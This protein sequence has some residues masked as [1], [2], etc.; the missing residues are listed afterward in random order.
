MKNIK[1]YLA[2]FFFILLTTICTVTA[3]SG[4]EFDQVLE[5]FELQSDLVRDN[6][7]VIDPC[8]IIT[9]LQTLKAV[10]LLEEDLY[11]RTYLLNRRSIL[12]Y[13][14]WVL[15]QQQEGFYNWTI[16]AHAFYNQTT[17]CNFTAKS[18]CIK[19]YLAI[20][21]QDLIDKISESSEAI[22]LIIEGFDVDPLDVLPLF[23]VF[24]VQE[25]RTGFM[26]HFMRDF[27]NA[28]IRW[29]FPIYYI[30]KNF[31]V[32]N[33]TKFELEEK[34][35]TLDTET[36]AEFQKDHLV[37]DKFGMGDLRFELEFP[38]FE[39][40]HFYARVGGRMT[41]PTAFPFVN[42]IM[43]S[44]FNRCCPRPLFSFSEIFEPFL[45]P[46]ESAA[47]Q[48]EQATKVLQ[49]FM[50]GALDHLAANLLDTPLGNGGHVGF[51]GYGY[52]DI[53][54]NK[55]LNRP[56]SN[57]VIWRNKVILEYLLPATQNR[58]FIT[59]KD[60]DAFATRNFDDQSQCANNLAFLNE[61]IV[62]QF[63][64]MALQATVQ[65]GVI[66][67]WVTEFAYNGKHFRPA[68]GADL[69]IQGQESLYNI[70]GHEQRMNQLDLVRA[71]APSAYQ[72]KIFGSLGGVIER[73]KRDWFAS[74]NGDYTILRS[75]I[76]QD[77]TLTFNFEVNF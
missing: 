50:L 5:E 42:G 30:E 55:F 69:W 51:G 31:F 29:Y 32:D 16:G 36:Q 75:G 76:G 49:D 14:H 73:P 1:K 77:Y 62:D 54:M 47:E 11:L 28:R 52:C 17:R 20:N 6:K 2:S 38:V 56:W 33:R 40:E 13:P 66:F 12:D 21:N 43:G 64:P 41:L 25:R 67:N 68:W 57:Y 61:R 22:G 74:I 18:S 7:M 58:Y 23:N 59:K 15:S 37:S 39:R 46:N 19:D 27:N 63:Y 71:K 70:Q 9:V 45:N 4:D 60:L 44:D 34:L 72:L 48:K 10:D 35:G 3:E 53:L 26:A 24:T 8:E 65:P